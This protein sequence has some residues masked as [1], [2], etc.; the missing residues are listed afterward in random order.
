[1]PCVVSR[2]GWSGGPGYE[3]FPL[4]SE[5]ALEVWD[6]VAAAGQPLGMLVCGPNVPRA[7]ERGITDIAWFHNLGV[8]ALEAAERLVDLD[9]GEFV[10]R[11]RAARRRATAG[12]RRRTS[13][14]EGP[15]RDAAPRGRHL[16]A[17]TRRR[18]RRRHA[19]G[20]AIAGARPHDRRSAS[21]SRE[22]AEP[23]TELALVA[24]G[25][26]RCRSPSRRCRS[27][28]R[29][30][31]RTTDM[32]ALSFLAAAAAP[33]YQAVAALVARAVGV[34]EPALDEPGLVGLHDAL[35]DPRP[36][37]AFLCGL[38]YVRLR[39]RRR[40]GRGARGA[41][42]GAAGW[43][44]GGGVL[45]RARWPD[46]AR[47][48]SS[49]AGSAST[50]TTR[51]RA[52]CCR[53]RACADPDALQ[54]VGPTGSHRHS[55]E[56]L[57][58]GELDAA[59]IDASVLRLEL[60][61]HPASAG[62]WSAA[63]FGPMP[64]PPVVAFGGGHGAADRAAARAARAAAHRRAAAARWRSARCCATRRSRR[65]RT[66]R[67]GRWIGGPRPAQRRADRAP[68]VAPQVPLQ[69]D[70][71]PGRRDQVEV[72][73]DRR[74]VRLTSSQVHAGQ[75]PAARRTP[76]STSELMA[77][78]GFGDRDLAADVPPAE[79]H[80]P[81]PSRAASAERRGAPCAPRCAAADG[82]SPR[83]LNV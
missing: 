26:R 9:A 55:L 6:A 14:A 57:A 45:R 24:P 17:D 37:L 2:T 29:R 48:R 80:R 52:G 5:R 83:R 4:G 50:T 66:H 63:R 58:A 19:L 81:S 33:H 31:A 68:Q 51:C 12:I 35:A 61:E 59:P 67:C 11:E 60:R 65:R 79:P 49:G 34:P 13:R 7:L 71:P 10:G 41:G 77:R 40:T 72:V 20:G 74:P 38:P 15:G 43:G 73:D 82:R 23:G 1:M 44:G 42:L 22:H 18:A 21:S 69:Q 28:R 25:R 3:V 53:A 36:A 54:W 56:L 70:R 39:D 32:R 30:R 46:P 16:A 47:P 76:S 75:P 64:A 8:N 62:S 78:C 27:S